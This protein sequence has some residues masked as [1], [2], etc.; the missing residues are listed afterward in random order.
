LE[1]RVGGAARYQ[2]SRVRVIARLRSFGSPEPSLTV[3]PCSRDEILSASDECPQRAR[4]AQPAGPTASSVNVPCVAAVV[5]LGSRRN[6]GA[7]RCLR[8]RPRATH[9]RTR[10]TGPGSRRP[11]R[12]CLIPAIGMSRHS[13][14]E[15]QAPGCRARSPRRKNGRGV[16]W[17]EGDSGFDAS[18][19]FRR[20]RVH[21]CPQ[22]G[23]ALIRF[24]GTR[25]RPSPL[26][27]SP[28]AC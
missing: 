15:R 6:Q 25:I 18:S 10:R 24:L 9:G 28:R 11:S 8:N 2:S 7:G 23:T 3:L 22:H 1:I 26:E 13:D 4:I 21:R 27:S 12:R 5:V 16:A 19:S 14:R 17:Q 20:P